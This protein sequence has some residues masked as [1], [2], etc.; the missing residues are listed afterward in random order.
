VQ[1]ESRSLLFRG[2]FLTLFVLSLMGHVSLAETT[3][4]WCCWYSMAVSFRLHLAQAQSESRYKG[5]ETKVCQEYR[6]IPTNNGVP[7][8]QLGRKSTVVSVGNALNTHIDCVM[9]LLIT[10]VYIHRLLATAPNTVFL[11]R[12]EKHYKILKHR[13]GVKS[14]IFAD[15]AIRGVSWNLTPAKSEG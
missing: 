5:V 2:I 10:T 8:R 1:V 4:K 12:N 13:L 3:E 14:Q 11:Q 7:F 6:C 9:S 15:C